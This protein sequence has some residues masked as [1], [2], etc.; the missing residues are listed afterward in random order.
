MYFTTTR[1]NEWLYL[2]WWLKEETAFVPGTEW[3]AATD[4]TR[5]EA[6]R[7]TDQVSPAKTY[8][9][10]TSLNSMV[11]LFKMNFKSLQTQGDSFR[12]KYKY[13]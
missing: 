1:K 2:V 11:L 9:C 8:G 3:G 12:N 7:T 5:A 10:P 6:G 4:P 13:I